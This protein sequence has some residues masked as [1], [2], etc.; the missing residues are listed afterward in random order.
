MK[1]SNTELTNIER[2]VQ[3]EQAF[4]C[5]DALQDHDV[6]DIY[7]AAQDA[8]LDLGI[9]I[10]SGTY[11]ILKNTA[12]DHNKESRQIRELIIALHDEWTEQ[13]E[14]MD[15]ANMDRFMTLA[16]ELEAIF[17]AVYTRVTQERKDFFNERGL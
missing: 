8:H 3:I 14:E 15:D 17:N 12:V 11:A 4:F 1:N 7:E 10:P 2:S 6:W 16:H 5:A 13:V 9:L